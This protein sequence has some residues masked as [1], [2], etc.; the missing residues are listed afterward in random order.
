MK[1]CSKFSVHEDDAYQTELSFALPKGSKLVHRVSES[2]L[3]LRENG[4]IKVL[5]KK[6]IYHPKCSVYNIEDNKFP[7]QYFGGIL[8]LFG[9]F[10][11]LCIIVLFCENYFTH[12]KLKVLDKKHVT[13]INESLNISVCSKNLG[14][15]CCHKKDISLQ[16]KCWNQLD[17][18]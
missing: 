1:Y 13:K 6:W 5:M 12:V 7:W 15:P 4:I 9:I 16:L 18:I 10:T 11:I 3:K 8:L 17:G 14:S 2:L